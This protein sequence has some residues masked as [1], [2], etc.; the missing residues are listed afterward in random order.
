[1]VGQN[2][3]FIIK[4][5]DPA[6]PWTDPIWIKDAPGIDPSLFWDDD[7]RCYYTG[8]AVIDGTKD[9]WPGKNGIS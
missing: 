8:A 6:G 3:N 5:K 2:G 1:M 4:A 7:G 9:E